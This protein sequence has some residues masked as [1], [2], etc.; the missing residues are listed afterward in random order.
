M[1]VLTE[2]SVSDLGA[3]AFFEGDNAKT[4]VLE[5]KQWLEAII[6]DKAPLVKPEQAL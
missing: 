4:G 1:G 3:I 2:E 6:E 5:C